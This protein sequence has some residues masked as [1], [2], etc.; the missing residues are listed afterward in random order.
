MK[1]WQHNLIPKRIQRLY[2]QSRG[3]VILQTSGELS[4]LNAPLVFVAICGPKFD[5]R[6]PNAGVTYRM[7]L[8]H[9]FEAIG[10]PYKLVNVFDFEEQ[11]ADLKS[12]FC[13]ISG[14]DYQFLSRSGIKALSRLQHFVWVNFWFDNS[15]SLYNKYGIP[16]L[17]YSDDLNRMILSSNPSFVFTPVSRS[18]LQFYQNWMK[19]GAKLISLPLACDTSIYTKDNPCNS[20]FKDVT[21]AFVGGYWPY[22]A[23]QFDRYLKPYEKHLTVFG[24]SHWPYAGYGG[25][26]SREEEPA[27]LRQ[28]IL[29]PAINEPHAEILGG[30]I[31]ERVYKV[32]GSGGMCITDAT[33]AH[34]DLFTDDELVMPADLSDYHELVKKILRDESFSQRYRERGYQAVM[35]RHTYTHRAQTILA[36]LGIQHP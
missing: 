19:N 5:Q 17:S 28:A 34:R 33:H 32:L 21:M 22:K 25:V 20:K 31:C 11:I 3:P 29:C 7:G 35:E 13:F 18:G 9:G 27:L 26:I 14:Y 36:N 4:S 23:R 1:T 16:N 12:P 24:Y 8:C 2:Y 10:I 30:D 15:S 6:I